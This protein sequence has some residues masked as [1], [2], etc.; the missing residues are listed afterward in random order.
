MQAYNKLQRVKA[1]LKSFNFLYN[2]N[3]RY[4][5]F[6]LHRSFSRLSKEYNLSTEPELELLSKKLQAKVKK[7]E[8]VNRR[9]KVLWVGKC[10]EQDYSGFIQALSKFVD[11]VIFSQENGDYGQEDAI[12]RRTLI[13]ERERFANGERLNHLYNEH[14]GADS[15]DLVIGQ[16]WSNIINPDVL[17]A[18]RE[19]GTIVV[20]IAMDDKLPIHWKSDSNGRLAGAI[21]LGQCVDLTLNTFKQAVPM[22]AQHNAP[23]IYWPLASNGDVFKPQEEKEY[24][25]VFIGSNYGYRSKVIE[26]IK[27]AGINVSAF[28]PGFPSG[29]VSAQDSADIFG[30]A[31]IVLGMGYISYSRKLSTLKLRDFDALFTGAMY[32]TSR[33][34]DLEELFEDGKHIVYYDTI[35]ELIDKL[36]FYLENDPLCKKIV[37]NALLE[38]KMNH[39]WEKRIKETF[40]FI[41]F[42]TNA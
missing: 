17:F 10:Y 8:I 18:I 4:K 22:Y 15:I 33:N 11:L 30:K 21:G 31:R 3:A 16:M 37:T 34:S 28:G 5:E 27:R 14:G 2:L 38:A 25:V 41:G 13:C 29:M 35:E 19:A 40:T 26:Q 20:N 32:I 36:K 24:D 6:L 9:L 7:R 23:C 39:T 1:K 12:H 42:D